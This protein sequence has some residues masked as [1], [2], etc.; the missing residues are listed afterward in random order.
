[1]ESTRGV[2]V[3]IINSN[4]TG[5]NNQTCKTTRSCVLR[6]AS[7]TRDFNMDIDCLV[8]P[9]ITSL[10][11]STNIKAQD[12]PLPSDICLADPSF[13]VPSSI[14]ILVGA[15]VFWSVIG[16]SR[17]NLGRHNPALFETKF[18]WL[19]SG[20]LY[21]PIK[22]RHVCMFTQDLDTNSS[23]TRFWE[24]DTILPKHNYTSEEDNKKSANGHFLSSN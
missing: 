9:K 12:I 20:V 4:V 5:I 3:G 7:Y 1:M 18:G 14:D 13:Y 22:H 19:L 15:D 2:T 23:L 16:T 11:P 21:Q 10:V 17:I 8:V 24:L 6:I